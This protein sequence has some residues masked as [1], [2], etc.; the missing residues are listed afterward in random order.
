MPLLLFCLGEEGGPGRH[1]GRQAWGNASREN[2]G[3]LADEE[4]GRMDDASK[5]FLLY[6][7]VRIESEGGV[8]ESRAST[9]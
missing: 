6:T 2:I 8:T 9:L 5:G 3:H 7:E 1:S 4:I